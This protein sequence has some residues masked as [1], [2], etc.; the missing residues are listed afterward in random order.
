MT[1]KETIIALAAQQVALSKQLAPVNI[2]VAQKTAKVAQIVGALVATTAE[3]DRA[4]QRNANVQSLVMIGA[5]G[6]YDADETKKV[7]VTAQKAHQ[8]AQVAA[9]GVRALE[10][11]IAGHRAAVSTYAADLATIEADIETAKKAYLFGLADDAAGRWRTAAKLLS[12]I[13]GELL[14]YHQA[15]AVAGFDPSI[16]SVGFWSTTVASLELPSAKTQWGGPLVT[17]DDI[18]VQQP[19]ALAAVRAQIVADGV[20]IHGLT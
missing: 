16:L 3:L 4:I 18:K 9:E 7:L 14:G 5:P 10:H 15:L 13:G 8:A 2:V 11:E 20:H 19:A 17:I 1:P 6:Q 12:S